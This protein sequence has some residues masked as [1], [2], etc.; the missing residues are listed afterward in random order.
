[1]ALLWLCCDFDKPQPSGVCVM[2]RFQKTAADG[3]QQLQ[4]TLLLKSSLLS[5][6]SLTQQQRQLLLHHFFSYSCGVL[7]LLPELK[8]LATVVKYMDDTLIAVTFKF[9][10]RRVAPVAG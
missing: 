4:P 3:L 7:V 5:L 1:M 2:Q 10:G 8:A 9:M 6:L